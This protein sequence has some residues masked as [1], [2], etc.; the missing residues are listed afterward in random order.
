M[1]ALLSFASTLGKDKG[2]A[3]IS[4]R[5]RSRSL[6]RKNDGKGQR[7][8]L[9]GRSPKLPLGG[10]LDAKVRASLRA[11]KARDSSTNS[12]DC[13]VRHTHQRTFPQACSRTESR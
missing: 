6:S 4:L 10:E 7:R 11:A 13:G 12:L 3:A 2:L 5:A 1:A 9:V 8:R